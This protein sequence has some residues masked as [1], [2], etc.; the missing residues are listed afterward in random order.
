[1]LNVLCNTCIS[2]C[3]TVYTCNDHL[4]ISLVSVYALTDTKAAKTCPYQQKV[5]IRIQVVLLSKL[6]QELF[7][8]IE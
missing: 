5:A 6:S 3:F 8:V 7:A 4:I 1:M 2:L